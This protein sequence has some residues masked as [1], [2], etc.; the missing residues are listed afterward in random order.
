MAVAVALLSKQ[1]ASMT[2]F[3]NCPTIYNSEERHAITGIDGCS[4]TATVQS[5]DTV[6]IGKYRYRDKGLSRTLT[7]NYIFTDRNLRLR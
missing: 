5:S 2:M 1:S 4:T 6:F 3:V 7:T